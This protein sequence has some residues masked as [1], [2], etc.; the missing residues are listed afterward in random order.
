MMRVGIIGSSDLTDTERVEAKQ[1]LRSILS[2]YGTDDELYHGDSAGIETIAAYLGKQYGMKVTP[3]PAKV[4]KWEGE[5]GFKQRNK[6]V[7]LSVE[8]LYTIHS[9]RSQTGGTIW[10]YNFA[11]RKNVDTQWIELT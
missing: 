5:G 10:T 6:R 7:A 11:N 2:E 9:P 8:K 4:K 1:I 3:L